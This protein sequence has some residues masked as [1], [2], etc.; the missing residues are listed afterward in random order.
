MPI[1]NLDTGTIL[2]QILILFL[3]AAIGYVSGKQATCLRKRDL[4]HQNL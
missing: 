4:L 3:L 2:T 1:E